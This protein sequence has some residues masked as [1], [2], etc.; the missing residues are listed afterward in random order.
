MPTMLRSLLYDRIKSLLD[1]VS[2]HLNRHEVHPSHLTLCGLFINAFGGLLYGYGHFLT[3]SMV[4]LIAGVFDM[5]D[6]ALARTA[7]KASK[8]GAFTDSVVDRYSDFLI[9][10]GLLIFF[11]RTGHVGFVSLVLV[12]IA[13]ALLTSYTKAR[14]ESLIQ[15][16]DVG[17]IERPERIVIICAG[18]IFQFLIP[19]LWFLAFT[20]HLTAFQRIYYTWNETVGKNLWQAPAPDTKNDTSSAQSTRPYRKPREV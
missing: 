7:D 9:F 15:H 17:W 1:K 5:L 3:G 10:G 20:T 19:A 18:G 13:G 4:I 14:A 16:C 11:A 6:G 2:C 12:V 8:F